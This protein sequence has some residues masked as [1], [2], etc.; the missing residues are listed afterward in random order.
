MNNVKVSVLKVGKQPKRWGYVYEGK[1]YKE[2]S[3][4]SQ[5]GSKTRLFVGP[6][7]WDVIE[8]LWNRESRPIAIYRMALPAIYKRLGIP[9]GTA[10]RWSQKAGCSCPCSPGFILDF[11]GEGYGFNAF[12]TIRVEGADGLVDPKK[13][14]RAEE[15]KSA[16]RL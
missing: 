5:P 12:A 1:W 7:D 8:N 15:R 11:H 4:S 10:A 9:Q 16:L 3:R 14:A 2:Y 13:A 6:E